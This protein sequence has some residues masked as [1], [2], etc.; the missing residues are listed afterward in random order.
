VSNFRQQHSPSPGPSKKENQDEPPCKRRGRNVLYNVLEERIDSDAK[1][2]ESACARD[3]TRQEELLGRLDRMTDGISE[4][5]K[6]TK[7]KMVH[8]R[9]QQM[10]MMKMMLEFATK[11]K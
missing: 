10:D 9:E 6:I 11:N 5:A 8:D 3:E 7:E 2:L 1:L 4:L